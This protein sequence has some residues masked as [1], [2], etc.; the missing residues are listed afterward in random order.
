MRETTNLRV[1][2]MNRKTTSIWGNLVTW[3][4]F[5]FAV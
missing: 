3:N 5:E 2:I 4:K 1:E